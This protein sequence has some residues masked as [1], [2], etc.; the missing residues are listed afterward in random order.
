MP[1]IG[2]LCVQEGEPPAVEEFLS[3]FVENSFLCKLTQGLAEG[4]TNRS[5]PMASAVLEFRKL[6]GFYAVL[7]N[8][9]RTLQNENRD[10]LQLLRRVRN[11]SDGGGVPSGSLDG[12]VRRF[13][14]QCFLFSRIIG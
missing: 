8:R 12:Q 6:L 3:N 9:T 14:H 4:G 13:L 1:K 2:K 7:K 10:L 11:T 5:E